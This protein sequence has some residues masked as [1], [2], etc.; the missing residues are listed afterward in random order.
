M[1]AFNATVMC[2]LSHGYKPNLICAPR[3]INRLNSSHSF[4]LIKTPFIWFFFFCDVC[5][6]Y[7]DASVRRNGALNSRAIQVRTEGGSHIL[8]PD[9]YEILKRILTCTA[10]FLTGNECATVG[11]TNGLIADRLITAQSLSPLWI[12]DCRWYSIRFFSIKI[13]EHVNGRCE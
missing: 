9:L 13:C 5:V 12:S 11:L 3:V 2:L 10:Y 4:I 8:Q 1:T 6:F 7:S